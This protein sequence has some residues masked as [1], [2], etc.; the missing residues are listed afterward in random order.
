MVMSKM[1]VAF[2]IMKIGRRKSKNEWNPSKSIRHLERNMGSKRENL[3]KSS[4]SVDGYEK[5]LN[6]RVE[7]KGKQVMMILIVMISF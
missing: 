6:W 2:D 3:I 1:G 4:W 5:P 7:W